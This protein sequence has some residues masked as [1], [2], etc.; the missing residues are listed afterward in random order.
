MSWQRKR[1]GQVRARRS[2]HRKLGGR[3][4]R[5]DP[6][7]NPEGR[8]AEPSRYWSEA[9]VEQCLEEY[10][11]AWRQDPERADRTGERLITLDNPGTA[12]KDDAMGCVEEHAGWRLTVAVADVATGVP[13]GGV[14]DREARWR[15]S[16]AYLPEAPATMI[17][18]EISER[19]SLEPKI[20]RAAVVTQVR[21][22]ADGAW[23]A[24]E[25]M[26]PAWVMVVAGHQGVAITRVGTQE[27]E[28][29][30]LK[31]CGE[32]LRRQL[33]RV[34]GT[35]HEER[36]D[37]RPRREGDGRLSMVTDHTR[38]SGVA[39]TVCVAN[40]AAG[41]WLEAKNAQ[42]R[43]MLRSQGRGT[44]R[45][46]PEAGGGHQLL[47]G[48]AYAP[49]TS[50][51]R[52]YTEL[53]NQRA[54]LAVRGRVQGS[55]VDEELCTAIQQAE[56]RCWE[57]QVEAH[58]AWLAEALGG[59]RSKSGPG[60]IVRTTPAGLFVELDEFPGIEA[61]CHPVT[62]EKVHV[63]YE[64][65]HQQWIGPDGRAIQAGRRG[66]GFLTARTERSGVKLGASLLALDADRYR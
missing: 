50:P 7:R 41:E 45:Y 18:R 58:K 66:R 15:G 47:G 51:L 5:K 13:A 56:K 35:V 33:E 14:A 48:R 22:E 11:A 30:A 64:H 55:H 49:A 6:A 17:P 12:L 19:C 43:I 61:L 36:K 1:K 20:R 52:R 27:P 42:G 40:V 25:V 37:P 53:L 46:S 2:G 9:Q 21:V 57:A 16:T 23:S 29:R 60:T 34:R 31:A 28:A 44:G 26:E 8:T 4:H 65:R 62:L 59:G 54:A 39:E 3:A 24:L 63:R 38:G 32:A 10:E